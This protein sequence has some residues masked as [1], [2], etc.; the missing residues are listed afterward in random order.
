MVRGKTWTLKLSAISP[1][2]RR[3]RNI[4]SEKEVQTPIMT[5]VI[6]TSWC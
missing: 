2:K 6:E 5:H 3:N 4:K 1:P